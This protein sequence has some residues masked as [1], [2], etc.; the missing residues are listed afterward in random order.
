MTNSWGGVKQSAVR[1]P[2]GG[3]TMTKQVSSLEYFPFNLKKKKMVSAPR[4]YW[5]SDVEKE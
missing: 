3:D 1:K 4:E 2:T 5:D